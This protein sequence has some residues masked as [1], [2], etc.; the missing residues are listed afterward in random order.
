MTYKT[1]PFSSWGFEYQE[2]YHH[3]PP[4]RSSRVE[5]YMQRVY[6][7]EVHK[8][9][10]NDQDNRAHEILEWIHSNVHGPFSIAST[11][12]Y[13]YYVIFADDFSR[14]C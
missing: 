12:R 10:F 8:A 6:L 14:K 3:R 2:T 4:K 9:T 7:R 13:M 5:E 11:T 1:W